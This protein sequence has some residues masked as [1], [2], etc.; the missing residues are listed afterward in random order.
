D[1]LL[2]APV[3]SRVAKILLQHLDGFSPESCREVLVQSNLS[4]DLLVDGCGQY[5]FQRIWQTIAQIKVMSDS[6][7]LVPTLVRDTQGL[8]QAFSALDLEQYHPLPKE[9]DTMNK[10][11][12]RYYSERQHLESFGQQKNHLA[13]VVATELARMEKKLAQQDDVVVEAI[14]AE[15]YKLY[16]ELL[17]ANMHLLSKGM[18]SIIVTNYYEPKSPAMEIPLD[19]QFTPSQQVQYYYKKYTKARNGAKI[20]GEHREKVL[21]EIR[22]LESV[23]SSID[24][25]TTRGELLEIKIE[26]GEEGYIKGGSKGTKIGAGKAEFN[27]GLKS[28]KNKGPSTKGGSKGGAKA[29]TGGKTKGNKAAITEI[30]VPMEFL[31][32]GDRTVLVGKNN[33]QN[34]YLT[35]K[36]ARSEDLWLHVKELPGSHVIIRNQGQGEVPEAALWEAAQLAAYFSQARHSGQVPVDYTL[37]KH[38][39]KPRGAKPGMVIYDQQKTIYVT[40]EENTIMNLKKILD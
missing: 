12:D 25:A 2:A 39:R 32:S 29:T 3:E 1:L 28:G 20:A 34:D 9:H 21:E 36:I 37:R 23:A 11:L 16:G 17:T 15:T 13:Q 35:L 6:G 40:P 24:Q 27:K 7:N 30:P 5:E 26:L 38:V 10:L 4:E 8:A 19:L 14:A 33:R 18:S 22:Y 31:V